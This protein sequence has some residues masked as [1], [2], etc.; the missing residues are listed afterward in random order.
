MFSAITNQ[1]KVF[2]RIYD[3]KMNDDLL[4]DF[5]M[6]LLA[7]VQRK[8]YLILDNLPV[9][10]SKP[11]KRWLNE[12]QS[13]IQVFYLPSYSPELN[14]DEYLNCDL[15]TGVHSG[16][17]ARNKECLK[18]KTKKYMKLLQRTPSRVRKYFQNENIR[19]A[20]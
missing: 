8:V 13:M 2:F 9:H 5:M 12:H 10:H 4:I 14:P 11:V 1:G 20:A 16:I 3:G 6:R 17:P 7:S 18:E 15:K 19:Y